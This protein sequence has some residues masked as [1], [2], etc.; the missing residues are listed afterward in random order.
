MV[1]LLL[2]NPNPLLDSLGEEP[3]A[4]MAVYLARH[5]VPVEVMAHYTDVPVGDALETLA[6]DSDASLIVAGAYGHTRLR[7]VVLGGVTRTLL[8]RSALPLLLAH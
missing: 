5:G 3:G 4:D 8:G 2:I 1:R 7:E 6:R